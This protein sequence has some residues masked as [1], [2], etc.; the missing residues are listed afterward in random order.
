MKRDARI[1]LAVVLVLGLAVTLL[2]ARAIAK[3]G[4]VAGTDTETAGPKDAVAY[5]APSAPAV[6]YAG[7]RAVMKRDWAR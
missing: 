2:V 3:R 7:L 6:A 5:S 1:G 4:E